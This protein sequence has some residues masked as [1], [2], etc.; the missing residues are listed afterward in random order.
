MTVTTELRDDLTLG[1]LLA[2]CR[3]RETL[4]L[5][6]HGDLVLWARQNPVEY[7]AAIE[8]YGRLQQAPTGP[9]M[10]WVDSEDWSL[11]VDEMTVPTAPHHDA[12]RDPALEI[13]PAA[14]SETPTG[15]GARDLARRP[16]VRMFPWD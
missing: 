7:A 6:S 8:E 2:W 1:G 3:E 13:S 10:D 12:S 11:G 5:L 9:A 15:P 4:P 14:T 16:C